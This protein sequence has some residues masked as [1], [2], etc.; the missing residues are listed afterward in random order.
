MAVKEQTKVDSFLTTKKY[1]LNDN[2]QCRASDALTSV[3]AELML[4]LSIVE[5]PSFKQFTESLDP[6]F[7]VPSRST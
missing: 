2:R 5:A 6:R 4:P 1:G 7:V 3:V